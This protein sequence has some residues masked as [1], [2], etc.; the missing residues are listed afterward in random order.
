M[1]GLT[2]VPERSCLSRAL[3]AAAAAA[4]A[5]AILGS[6]GPAAAATGGAAQ[7]FRPAPGSAAGP[8]VFAPPCA[9]TGFSSNHPPP[10]LGLGGCAGY[11]ASGHDFRYAQAI[12]TVPPASVITSDV[13]API[14]Y[15]GL[16]SSDAIA[17]TGLVTCTA[18]LAGFGS[19]GPDCAP[20]DGPPAVDYLA[21]GAVVTNNGASVQAES[22]SLAS[23]APG[24]GVGVA[25]Y[26]PAGGAAHFTITLPG[27]AATS[28]QLPSAG[29][30][31]AVFG[32][33]VALVEYAATPP[34]SPPTPRVPVPGP[35]PGP[36]DL[37]IT[38]FQRGGW[39]TASGA[40]GTFTGPWAVSP[41]ILTSNGVAPPGGTIEVDPAHLWN[42]GLSSGAGDAFGIWWRH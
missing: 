29:T 35:A 22:V 33:A 9:A 42:D 13:T 32:H 18:F 10:E 17:I 5:L 36:V 15:V 26:A 23:T 41:V 2:G 39:T 38:Q 3:A 6:A 24:D 8:P 27:G 19:P 1:A 21:F 34:G 31:S 28:F 4:S 20:V 11:L 30:V 7:Q 16:T 14:L 12:I 40:R 37:R 25:V